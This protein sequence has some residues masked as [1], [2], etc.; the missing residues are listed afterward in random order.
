MTETSWL[1]RDVPDDA[2]LLRRV[3]PKQFDFG[4][5]SPWAV[6][7]G[8]DEAADSHSVN[9]EE[10]T[11]QE[12]TLVGHES[13]GVVALTAKDYRDLEQAID[14]TP[15]QAEDNYGHC[16]AIGKKTARVKKNLKKVA[17]LRVCP[18]DPR[19]L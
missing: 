12:K 14:H 13:F 1:P 19:G 17:K 4:S 16:D 8:N 10:H 5:C 11:S 3:H 6:V 15:N 9:W 7:F 18:E 2:V